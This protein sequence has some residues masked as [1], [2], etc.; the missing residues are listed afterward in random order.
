MLTPVRRL[1]LALILAL[2]ILL[3]AEAALHSHSLTADS[4][5]AKPGVCAVCAF[6]ADGITTTAPL[7][8]PHLFVAWLFVVTAIAAVAPGSA[9]L[10]PSRGPPL[11]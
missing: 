4:S 8:V 7:P 3:P 6:G 1:Q 10:L 11:A 5:T 9:R 2:A